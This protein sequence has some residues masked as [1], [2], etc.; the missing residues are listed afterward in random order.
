MRRLVLAA[1]AASVVSFPCF[2]QDG[3]HGDHDEG[4]AEIV[5]TGA[6][7]RSR[8]ELMSASS[9]LTGPEL[10]RDL[11]ANIGET[12]ARQP[13]VSAT[14]FGPNASR[15]ILRGFQGERVRVLSD[16]IGSFDVSNTS[17]DHA[18]IIN[19]LTADRIEVLRGPSALL[20]GS[21]AIGGVVN[22]VDSRIPRAKPS[23][24]IH[25]DGLATYGSA[26]NERFLGLRADV[27][28]TSGLVA[29][30]DGTFAKSGD[31]RAGGFILSPQLRAQAAASGDPD[32]LPLAQ[33]RGK[34]PNTAARNWE[35]AGGL[36]WIG[37]TANFGISFTRT[38]S[39]YGVPI[40]FA[41][42][43]LLPGEAGPE[44]VRLDARQ[45]RFDVRGEIS[46]DGSVF[47]AIRLRGGFADYTH[48][49][50]DETGAIGTQFFNKGK[51]VRAELI[52]QKRGGWEGA[53]GVQFMGRRFRVEG[54]EKFL[55]PAKS[56]QIGLFTVQSLERGPVRLEAGLR[57]ERS[58]AR[59]EADAALGN[60]ALFSQK[61]A[62][63]GAFGANISLSDDW[64]IGINATHAERA[65]SPEELF[66][67]GPH[68]GTQAFEIGDP[69]LAM[70]RSNGV[71]LVVHGEA[72]FFSISAAVFT[73]RFSNFVFEEQTGAEVDGLPVFAYRQA[74][75]T[76]S[77]FEL[78][79]DIR[80]AR[81]GETDI[82]LG[83]M[84]DATRT[85]IKNAGLSLPAP[86]IP[87]ARLRGGLSA[88]ADNYSAR[89][90]FE[91]VRGKS[92]VAA[93]ETATPAYNMVN[94]S[95]TFHPFGKGGPVTLIASADNIF[96]ITARRHA[97]LLK[98]YAPLA[99]RDMRM[100]VRLSF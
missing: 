22:V 20:Y 52:Q 42:T 96:D 44:E 79:I 56:N 74:R 98:D 81:F 49:E 30:L 90:E 15:P 57:I 21:S 1:L 87:A 31:M 77:G 33:L 75:A 17:A 18:V 59:A 88:E 50:L 51:E 70:E 39:R 91:R 65:P 93:L 43:P 71:E 4:D 58:R 27:S 32:I 9:V 97:S 6:I 16:G 10:D 46:P 29:H 83:V 53:I 80:L 36:A 78:E 63:S 99:G 69:N 38:E 72:S 76:T 37:D 73:S 5:V 86:R 100:T 8:A 48:D 14:S 41:T 45:S 19:P 94:A 13:G 89:I 84:S 7:D 12:L 54:D 47:K 55:P 24:G 95:L 35:V 66:S 60:P 26:A 68:A 11:R 3:E 34:I 62:L 64:R 67:N 2:A 92:R 28:L 23:E 25:I 40:R 82:N 85:S 61:T